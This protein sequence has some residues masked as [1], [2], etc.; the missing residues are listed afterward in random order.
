M[1]FNGGSQLTISNA[2][3]GAAISTAIVNTILGGSVG[4]ITAMAVHRC[5]FK[6]RCAQGASK[7]S[8][9]SCLM[10]INGGLAGTTMYSYMFFM[11][12]HFLYF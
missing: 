1:A 7:H 3:D 11:V 2:G 9:W 4:G 5:H 10:T 12:W 6:V 8:F